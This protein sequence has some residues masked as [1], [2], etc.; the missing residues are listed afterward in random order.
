LVNEFPEQGSLV[1]R[2]AVDDLYPQLPIKELLKN[3]VL[4]L[5][6]LV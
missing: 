4:V 3:V 6:A 2:Q 5:V 1:K